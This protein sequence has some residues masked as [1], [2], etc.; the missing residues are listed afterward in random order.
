QSIE[1]AQVL[2]NSGPADIVVLQELSPEMAPILVRELGP[3]YPY[4]ALRPLPGAAGMGILSRYPLRELD[5][6]HLARPNS[7]VQIVQVD[8]GWRALTLYNCHPTATNVLAYIKRDASVPAEVAASIRDRE[9]FIRGMLRDVAGRPGP[10][11][12]AG[13]WNSTEQSEVYGMLTERLEDS[14]AAAGWGF[15]HTFPA[16]RGTFLGIPTLPRTMRLDM[17]FYSTQ[18]VALSSRAGARYGESDHLP[19]IVQLAWR[20]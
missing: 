7:F 11:I 13:D 10:V 2:L 14:H 5:S 4:R 9:S 20:E 1:T 12:V 18:L 3:L 8:L 15:Q 6:Q 19:L 17:V 16:Y